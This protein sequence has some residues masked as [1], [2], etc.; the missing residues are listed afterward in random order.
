VSI[1]VPRSAKRVVPDAHGTV[2]QDDDLI[3]NLYFPELLPPA[4]FGRDLPIPVVV[5]PFDEE[6][7]FA[8]DSSPIRQGFLT[9]SAAEVP[10]KY[11]LSPSA[12]EG[13]R[14]GDTCPDAAVRL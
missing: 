3:M 5:V 8:P 14:A 6:D 1:K 9:R 2:A 13:L 12:T 11:R 10:R 4:E 7:V